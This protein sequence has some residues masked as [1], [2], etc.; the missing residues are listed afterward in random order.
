MR[1]TRLRSTRFTALSLGVAL[2][3]GGGSVFM[4]ACRQKGPAQRV[5]EKLDNAKEKVGDAINP[6]GPVEKAGRK[7]DK[8]VDELKR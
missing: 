5:G 7:I 3:V 1:S 6:K 4:S 2:T 8:S